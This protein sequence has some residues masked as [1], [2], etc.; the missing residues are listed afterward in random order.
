[1]AAPAQITVGLDISF[2]WRNDAAIA[3]GQFTSGGRVTRPN[4]SRAANI[5]EHKWLTLDCVCDGPT[6]RSNARRAATPS[7]PNAMTPDTALTLADKPGTETELGRKSFVHPLCEDFSN[8]A[9][10]GKPAQLLSQ[11]IFALCALRFVFEPIRFATFSAALSR[12]AVFFLVPPNLRLT[13]IPLI[14]DKTTVF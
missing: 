9:A 3:V 8:K 12:G 14:S 5:A 11:A 4:L 13:P 10:Q 6:R 2:G 1:M 7:M